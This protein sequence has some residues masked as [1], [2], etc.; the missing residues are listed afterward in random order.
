MKRELSFRQS[1]YSILLH[2]EPKTLQA[3]TTL[4]S[5]VRKIFRRSEPEG[6]ADICEGKRLGCHL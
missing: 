5:S 4:R 1:G 3:L 6:K 2:S